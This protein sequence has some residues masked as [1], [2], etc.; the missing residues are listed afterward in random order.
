MRGSG[1]SGSGEA[2]RRAALDAL[3]ALE[4]GRARRL[5]EALSLE[6]LSSRDAG[7][8]RELATGVERNRAFLDFALSG[9]AHRGLPRDPFVL[10]ALRVGAYQLLLLSRVP[11]HAAVHETVELVPR[12]KPL[13]NA[14]LR[15]LARQVEDRVANPDRSG[16][17][18][19]LDAGR[20]LVLGGPGLP[21]DPV[22]R[23]ALRHSLPPFLVGRWRERFGPD[24]AAQVCAA[25]SRRPSLHL[26]VNRSKGSVAELQEVL[27]AEGVQTV[28][29]DH[30]SMLRWEGGPPPFSGSAFAEGWFVVQD[31][32]ALQA[33]EAIAA[34]PGDTVIDLCAAPGTKATFLAEQVCPGGRVLAYDPSASRRE[35]IQENVE[36]L[37]LSE[38]LE[39]VVGPGELTPANRV[40]VDVPCSNTGVL[41]R[42]VEV[43]RRIDPGLFGDLAAVQSGLLKQ[44]MELV[45]PGGLLV[46]S[47]CSIESEENGDVVQA[48]LRDGWELV[49]EKLTLPAPPERDGGYHAVLRSCT[50]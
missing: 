30:P 5:R 1:R 17:E 8:A 32:T 48:A 7:L 47:T 9:L 35:R 16:T 18:V 26:R 6:G 3:V 19:A 10:C 46:Y 44:G 15:R 43:R 20:T 22:E 28:A 29:G 2:S 14:L 21:E 38:T 23:L 33:A 24:R 11:A 12:L 36:R 13:V 45:R 37:G 41:A 4:R 27:A 42:R 34:E 40:L 31:P 49:R 39:V 25:S 50:S